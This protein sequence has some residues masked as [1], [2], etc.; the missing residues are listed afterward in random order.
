MF[1]VEDYRV[2]LETKTLSRHCQDVWVCVC[3]FC[4]TVCYWSKLTNNYSICAEYV[5]FTP[6]S[7]SNE[8]RLSK[9]I[10]LPR[11]HHPFSPVQTNPVH[12]WVIS[13][14]RASFPKKAT[15]R[16][17]LFI[18][19]LKTAISAE[20]CSII[21]SLSLANI[22]IIITLHCSDYHQDLYIPRV[23]THSLRFLVNQCNDI[24][25]GN[26]HVLRDFYV[27]FD[28]YT[29]R[30]HY[31]DDELTCGQINK[32][33][34]G[35]INQYDISKHVLRR[36]KMCVCVA[37]L[38]EWIYMY[39]KWYGVYMVRTGRAAQLN[40]CDHMWCVCVSACKQSE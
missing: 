3:I 23:K 19:I 13:H 39:D 20:R 10:Q 18:Y 40:I 7:S 30:L 25:N 29:E 37:L 15:K 38:D 12:I 28:N 22:T 9:H 17:I 1:S 11:A 26:S 8:F 32:S 16:F 21:N 33:R 2:A 27:A 4:S 6:Q 31:A 5:A 24:A 34:L 36:R 35:I 14:I